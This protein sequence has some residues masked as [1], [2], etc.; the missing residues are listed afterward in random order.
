M[1][2][3]LKQRLAHIAQ[4]SI[5]EFSVKGRDVIAAGIKDNRKIGE[6]L[7]ELEQ[8]WIDSDFSLSHGELLARL[9]ELIMQKS[10]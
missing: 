2:P 7:N 3:D 1:L 9:P 10:A 8:I 5:P 4:I 6:V